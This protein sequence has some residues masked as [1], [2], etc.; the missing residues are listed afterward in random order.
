M[1]YSNTPAN[2]CI[3]SDYDSA[4]RIN[5][6]GSEQEQVFFEN[7]IVESIEIY[8]QA[9]Y[10]IPRTR[11]TT[12]DVLNEIQES[13]FD[14]AYLCR[15]YVNNVEGWE[16]QGELLSKFGIRI[17]DKTTF[18]ISRK[19]FTEK[20]DD[21]VTLAV[22]GR[23]NEGDLIWFPVT[24]HLFEIKFVEAERPF[25]QLGKG[26]VWE[27]QCEL[28]EYSDESIDT[29]VADIDAVETTFANSIKLVMD[30][31][32]SG[33]FS[34]GETITGNLYTAVAAATIT[35]DAVTS[36]AASNGGQYYKAALPP[37]VTLTGGGGTGA[38]A[39]A[40]VSDAGLVTGFTVTA[41]GSGYTSAPTV[42]IQES[43]KDIHAEVKSWNN[44]TREL[45]II[46]RT[47]TFNVAEYLKGETSGAL[48]SPESYNTLN[49]TNS[50]Y[51]QNSLFETLDDDIIDWTEGN[52]FGY[53][54]NVS[55]T[56]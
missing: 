55:D 34:V 37:T 16:G 33:D 5:I 4:C 13:S 42:V 56:F 44:A 41:G 35:G 10:Y 45:Q 51:D 53:T 30:P 50:T 8:G 11:V 39:T 27:M 1:A 31:G 9:I 3:Q 48:W 36:L 46:N 43:P 38:T 20:V 54:G 7:L 25:Y 15:A 52:P 6:N 40:T 24:K 14:S 2:N 22:E 32:G 29:G 19:K 47:G 12:D 23:P 26:Y 17:E 49:N 21:N 18:V 28:F